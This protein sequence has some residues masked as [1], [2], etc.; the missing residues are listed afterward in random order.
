MQ[1]FADFL[2]KLAKSRW[3]GNA[4]QLDLHVRR[5]HEQQRHAQSFPLPNIIVGGGGGKVKMGGQHITL[6]STRRSPTCI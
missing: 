6:R 3:P 5:K 2:G 4:G 1:Q